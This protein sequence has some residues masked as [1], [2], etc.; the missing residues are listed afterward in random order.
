M[1]EL[2]RKAIR[3]SDLTAAELSRRSGV[4]ESGISRFLNGDHQLRTENVDR[5]CHT[6]GLTLTR[7]RPKPRRTKP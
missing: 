1:S 6:L 2:L 7:S 3:K 5:L 4:P